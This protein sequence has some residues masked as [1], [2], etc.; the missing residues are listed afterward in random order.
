MTDLEFKICKRLG[1]RLPLGRYRM[2]DGGIAVVVCYDEESLWGVLQGYLE[3]E[4]IDSDERR[5]EWYDGGY[6]ISPHSTNHFDLVEL[7]SD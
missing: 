7:L 4:G 3:R 1:V 6:Y 2:R 5:K